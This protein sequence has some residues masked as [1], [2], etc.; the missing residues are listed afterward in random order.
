MRCPEANQMLLCAVLDRIAQIDPS[1]DPTHDSEGRPVVPL[2]NA[3]GR[4]AER[5][6]LG[7]RGMPLADLCGYP[8]GVRHDTAEPEW[9]VFYIELPTGQVSW[10]MPQHVHEYD[11]HT[12]T[13]KYQ[14]IAAY[15]TAV[16]A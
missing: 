13:E 11:G 4:Y 7:L 10:H 15:G 3:A 14:R 1:L 16:W 2:A 6:R 8:A 5:Y 12:T 9:P